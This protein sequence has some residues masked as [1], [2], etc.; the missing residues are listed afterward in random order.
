MRGERGLEER[1]SSMLHALSTIDI[2]YIIYH[3]IRNVH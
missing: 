3:I 2:I 1:D